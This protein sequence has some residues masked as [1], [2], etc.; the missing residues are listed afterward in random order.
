[1]SVLE[2][3]KFN[4]VILWS[5]SINSSNSVLNLSQSDTDFDMIILYGNQRQRDGNFSSIATRSVYTTSGI[6]IRVSDKRLH[7]RR[8]SD[9]KYTV[10]TT[11]GGSA[12]DYIN[13]LVG[14]KFN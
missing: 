8:D 1:M 4:E 2:S 14:V 11:E 10:T 6:A 13:K 7:L 9:I 5:G 3:A 12:S